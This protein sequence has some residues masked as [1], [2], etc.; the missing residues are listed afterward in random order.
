MESEITNLLKNQFNT[1]YDVLSTLN[2]ICDNLDALLMD[3]AYLPI[4]R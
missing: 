3:L 4:E 2:S 1:K